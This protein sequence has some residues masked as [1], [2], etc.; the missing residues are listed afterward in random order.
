MK[1]REEYQASIFAKRDALLAKR[2]KHITQAVTGAGAAVCLAAALIIIPQFPVNL[3]SDITV[4]EPSTTNAAALDMPAS[5]YFSDFEIQEE[6]AVKTHAEAPP[7]MTDSAAEAV[8][9]EMQENITYAVSYPVTKKHPNIQQTHID[10]AES[11]EEVT[12]SDE[13]TKRN[14]FLAIM[15]ELINGRTEPYVE[16]PA[17]TG[18]DDTT[19]NESIA[20]APEAPNSSNDYTQEEIVSAAISHLP[21]DAKELADPEKAFVTITKTSQ[22]E[23]YYEVWFDINGINHKIRL[24]AETLE[25]IAVDS[26]ISSEESTTSKPLQS[27]ISPPYNPN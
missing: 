10:S 9:D 8:P 15:A 12:N 4:T 1:S 27:Q 22:G 24:N 3:Q 26:N 2:K 23:E 7:E 25:H 13:T 19:E 6:N 17:D 21:D 11:V 20:Y 16:Y 18:G 14:G 5:Q